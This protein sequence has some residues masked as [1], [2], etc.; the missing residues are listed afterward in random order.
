MKHRTIQALQAALSLVL[1]LPFH[2]FAQEVI[3][4]RREL[5][6]I[7]AEIRNLV[8]KKE[9]PSM[10]VSVIKDGKPVWFEAIGFADTETGRKATV[11]SVYPVGSVSKSIT[12][13]GIMHLVSAGKLDLAQSINP[14]ILPVELKD[15]DGHT[16]DIKLWQLVSM[17][18]GVN[19]AY[20]GFEDPKDI[21]SNNAELI[22]FFG[23]FAI[24]AFQP[25]TVY[26]YSNN[27]YYVSEILI[28][29]VTK[30]GFQEYL[31]SAVFGPLSMNS[32]FAYPFRYKGE[33]DF[34]TGY[35]NDMRKFEPGADYPS[36]GSGFWSS[37]SD[38]TKYALFHLGRTSKPEVI[39]S[40]HLDEM[41]DFR[42]GNSD[43]FGIGWFNTGGL[44]V[45]DGS[46]TGGNARI[47]VDRKND[48]VIVC[49]LNKTSPSSLADQFADRIRKVFVPDQDDRGFEEWR[50]I[51]GT[52]YAPRYE[53]EGVW[54]GIIRQ[55]VTGK[56]VPIELRFDDTDDVSFMIGGEPGKVS[57][58]KYN[59][60]RELSGGFS[61]VF[62]GIFDS[63]TRGSIKLKLEG[64]T[65]GGYIQYDDV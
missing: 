6:K 45:S 24:V 14:L 13:T 63:Q 55:P 62:P 60:F 40:K 64:D 28:D 54:K 52:P 46:V 5:L 38:L 1:C 30:S 51:Y 25:G 18:G 59:L 20:G 34:V 26:E 35:T 27:S 32:T 10:A 3:P 2:S 29:K 39:D 17:N 31:D 11:D 57:N 19:H 49:L 37:L 16:P 48:L 56:T 47:T 41:H 58:P 21:P 33:A 53:L 8:E 36:G 65:L 15:I 61:S 42:Q 50:R 43:L 44:L 7:R 23:R 22:D 9:I 12:A 4:D